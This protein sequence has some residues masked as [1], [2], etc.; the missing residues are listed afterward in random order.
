MKMKISKLIVLLLG[1]SILFFCFGC[2]EDEDVNE[3]EVM[4]DYMVDND[5]DLPDLI[6]DWITS[7]EAVFTAGPENYFII[8]LRTGDKN[9]NGTIDFEEGHI[10]GAHKVALA[11]VVDYVDTN[12]DG[13]DPILLVC[14][15]GQTVGFA[16]MALRLSGYT[17]VKNL[18]FAMSGWHS[19]FDVWTGNTGNASLDF[20]SGWDDS[21]PPALPSYG[22]PTLDTGAEDGAAILAERVDAL[23]AGGFLGVSGA[24]VL[25]N[26]TDYNV[27]NYWA[28]A[29]WTTYGH[30]T[31]A[32]Q[33]AAGDLG[34]AAGLGVV[35]PAGTNVTYCWTGQTSA[36]V[37]AWLTVLGYDAKSLKFGVNSTIYDNLPDGPKKWAAS[38]DYAYETGP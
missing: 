17:N 33:V 37:T 31:D 4:T 35:D 22:F 28:E 24:G 36:L 21:A 14:Y 20:S 3:F 34:I 2:D 29:D 27:I 10:A 38:M 7:A 32:Y 13:T 6:V 26:Y 30:V 9:A 15:S 8:D 5:M 1:I 11:D 16:N 25:E 12:Y 19:D 18:K 23:L